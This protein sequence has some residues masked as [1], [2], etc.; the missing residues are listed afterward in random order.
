MSGSK[1]L[2]VET[3]GERPDAVATSAVVERILQHARECFQRTGLR[4]TTI[5]DIAEAAGVVRQTIYNHFANKQDIFDRLTL[6]EM[7]KVHE[8]MRRRMTHSPV[9]ADKITEA[10]LTSTLIARE[11]PYLRRSISEMETAPPFRL[12]GIIYEWQRE[13]WRSALEAGRNSGELTPDIAVD[14]MVSWLALCQWVLQIRLDHAPASE[15]ELRRY[16]RNFVVEPLLANHGATA[17]A[18]SAELTRARQQLVDLK[19]ILADQAI[20]IISL[21]KKL[22]LSS[23]L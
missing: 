21:E 3:A 6:N 10:V 2:P 9:F 23:S 7:I 18:M 11:N 16:I 20:K 15:V 14:E 13:H 8:E 4:K 1:P 17:V 5:E 19:D 22:K 12:T